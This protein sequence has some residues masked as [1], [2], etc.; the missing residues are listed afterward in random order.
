M[1][2][3]IFF[4][5]KTTNTIMMLPTRDTTATTTHIRSL[6]IDE[7]VKIPFLD[8]KSFSVE[9]IDPLKTGGV[10]S[11]ADA[12]QFKYIHFLKLSLLNAI[13]KTSGCELLA[14]N[15]GWL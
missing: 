11:M 4:V 3:C 14:N 7:K 8:M 9:F 1:F 2:V 10:L 5:V 13:T 6:T 12:T 15:Y